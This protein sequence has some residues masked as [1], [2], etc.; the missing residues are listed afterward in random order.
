MVEA[1]YGSG[2]AVDLV[3]EISYEDGRRAALEAR[4]A[5]DTVTGAAEPARE[6]ACA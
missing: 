2:D 4:M 6:A 3:T 5:I 1:F